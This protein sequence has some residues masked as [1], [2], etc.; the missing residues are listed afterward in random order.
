M[1]LAENKLLVTGGATDIGLEFSK[2]FLD[3]GSKVLVCGRR[4]SL[5]E[6]LK[7]QYPEV[8]Y[9]A[10]DLSKDQFNRDKASC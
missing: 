4:Q 9:L 8:E 7:Q 1:A 5:L 10:T 2:M 6:D 3:A